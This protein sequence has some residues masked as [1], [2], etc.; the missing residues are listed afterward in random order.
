MLDVRNPSLSCAERLRSIDDVCSRVLRGEADRKAVREDLKTLVW[1]ASWPEPLRVHTLNLLLNDPDPTGAADAREMARLMLPREQKLAV[2]QVLSDAAAQKGWTETLPALVRSLSR[3]DAATPDRERPEYRAIET[4]R[5]GKPVAE[6]VLDVFRRPPEDP[7]GYAAS[8]PERI[9]AD[10]WDVLARLD[11]TGDLRAGMITGPVPEDDDGTIASLREC[12]RDLHTLPRAGE[13][14]KWLWSLRRP[15]IARNAAWWTE[16]TAAIKPLYDDRGRTLDLRHAEPIRWAARRRPNWVSASRIEL[17]AETERRWAGRKVHL[18]TEREGA[19]DPILPQTLEDT[20]DKLNWGDLLT[21]LVV[22]EA[23]REPLVVQTLF[24]QADMDR[25]DRTAE[26]GGLLEAWRDAAGRPV[27]DGAGA[28]GSGPF[29]VVLYPP[30]PGTR[31]GDREFVASTDM[32]DQGDLALAHYHFHVQEARNASY[33]GPAPADLAY[34]TRLG[35]TCLVFTSITRDVLNVDL[36]QPD[37]T[38]VDLGDLRR[39]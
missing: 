33:A 27:S 23:V 38:I 34:A 10:A 28:D 6:S 39:P 2:I 1:S 24:A 29:R 3:F 14:L 8:T 11:P 12:L 32:I 22:D 36:Y 25:A 16:A 13:E 19:G 7:P 31:R 15:D 4:L 37:G 18:R 30:R 5:P 26:Y 9:R 35:R 20:R 17:L 21:L